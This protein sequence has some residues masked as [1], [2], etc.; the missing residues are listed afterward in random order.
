[1]SSI[2]EDKELDRDDVSDGSELVPAEV[3]ARKEREGSLP[4]NTPEAK[5]NEKETDSSMNTTSGYTVSEQGLVNNY[6]VTPKVYPAK[7]PSE[8]EQKEYAFQGGL[9]FLLVTVVVF[10]AYLATNAS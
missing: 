7:P 8:E 4:P 6:A 2:I 10:I 9:A 3:G 1:M 5:S